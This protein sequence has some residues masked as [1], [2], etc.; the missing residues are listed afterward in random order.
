[1]NL[2]IERQEIDDA[3]T[4]GQEAPHRQMA[5]EVIQKGGTVDVTQNGAQ[6]GKATTIDE[7]DQLLGNR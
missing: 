7:L 6:V 2:Q 4:M 3:S 5:V 1:M